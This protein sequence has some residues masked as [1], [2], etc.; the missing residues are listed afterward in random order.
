MNVLKLA[1]LSIIFLY[2]LVV[3]L[4]YLFQTKLIFYP[5]K[6]S[7]DFKFKIGPLD[8]EV[9][10]RTSDNE[11]VNGLFFRGTRPEVILYFHGNAGD[12]HGWQFVAE[13]FTAHGYNV[14][15]IDYRG[16]GKSSGVISENGFYKDAEAAWYFL[17]NKKGFTPRNI[18]IYGRSIGSGVAVEL[19]STHRSRLLI[20]ESPYAS[21]GLLAREKFPYFFPSFYLK[22]KF[23]NLEKI[24]HVKSPVIF[25]HG[26][27]DTLIP[28]SH[29]ER[30][31][32][33]AQGKKEKIIIPGG[34]HNDLN[35]YP[36]YQDFLSGS[37]ANLK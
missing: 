24:A 34:S 17:I 5:G 16:Y 33:K 15:I 2:A 13:D 25:I 12:L 9:F 10:L 31:F 22:H 36:E 18:I 27:Q 30:L 1:A 8:E 35:S 20:L 6:L 29:T 26:Q 37:L 7:K 23:N 19:A 28:P 14:F 11:E 32:L 21:L 4:F 3:L